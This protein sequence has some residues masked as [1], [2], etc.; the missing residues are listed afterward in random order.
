[1]RRRGVSP[2][3]LS[4]IDS[5][6]CGFGAVILLF[7]ILSSHSVAERREATQDLRSEVKRLEEAVLEGRKRLV[8]LRNS[9]ETT[10]TEQER[11]EGLSQRMIR[12]IEERTLQLAELDKDNLATQEHINRLKADLKSREEGRKRLEAG[13]RER[14]EQGERLREFPGEG[15]RQYLTDLKVGGKRILILMDSSASMLGESIVDVIRRR[16]LPEADRRQAPKW[17]RALKT[18]D[19]LTAQLPVSAEIQ[20]YAFNEQAAPVIEGTAGRWLKAAD[21]TTLDKAVANLRQLVPEKG[22]S[23]YQAVAALRA[24]SPKPDNVFLITDGLPTQGK[25]P[26]TGSKV[27]GKERLNRFRRAVEQLPTGIPVNIILFP[28]E[29]DPMAASAYW[30]LAR[31]SRGSLMSP[32][33]DWP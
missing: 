3:S 12:T 7:L 15:D 32:S 5:I 29:G 4:F 22:T 11:L 31:A 10:T 27:S 28:M 9:V 16:N 2:F 25:T 33:R 20:I 30:Q 23:L 19:W 18:V 26:D 6:L 8:V 21:V 24:M 17:Q 1:M 14:A 13:A